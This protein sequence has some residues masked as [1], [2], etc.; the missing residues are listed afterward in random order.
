MRP[1]VILWR[2]E[3]LDALR[4]RRTLAM[5]LLVPM[6]LYPGLLLTMGRI[7]AAGRERLARKEIVVALVDDEAAAL[8]PPEAAG[9]RTRFVRMSREAAEAGLREGKSV[10]AAVALGPEAARALREG[11]PAQVTLLFTRRRDLSMEGRDRVKAV[12]TRRGIAYVEARLVAARLPPS[13]AKPLDVDEE[14]IDFKKDMG[15][16]LASRILPTLLLLMLFLPAFYASIDVT[17]GEK[18]R[19]TFETLLVAPLHPLEVMVGKYLAVATIAVLATFL[20][21]GVM[22]ATFAAGLTLAEGTKA[23]VYLS[24]GQSVLIVGTLIPAALLVAAVSL[25]VASLARSFREGQT[26]LTPLLLLGTVP[27]L[28]AQSPGVELNLGTACVPLLNVALVVKAAALGNATWAPVLVTVA[29]VSACVVVALW[30]AA[31]AFRSEAIR[32][33]GID[34]WREVFRRRR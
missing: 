30:L 2:K 28:A 34:A 19:G 32:F 22:S 16:L 24:W 1:V 23:V 5:M 31:N 10:G 33:G 7:L 6:V 18:E 13:Y 17:A 9:P 3:L 14:D 4:D 12:L 26:L 8:L 27:G 20:N 29:S 11:R 25:T 15:P 21:L